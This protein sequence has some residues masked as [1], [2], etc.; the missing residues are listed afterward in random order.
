[1]AALALADALGRADAR[2]G[3]HRDSLGPDKGHLDKRHRSP[4]CCFALLA[5]ASQHKNV[6][7]T[8]SPPTSSKQAS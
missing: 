6:K 7:L 1:L 8:T 2:R 4:R 5:E 3:R